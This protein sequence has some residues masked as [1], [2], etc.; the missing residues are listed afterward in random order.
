MLTD[1]TNGHKFNVLLSVITAVDTRNRAKCHFPST[2]VSSR[3]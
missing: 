1:D 2:T 3:A